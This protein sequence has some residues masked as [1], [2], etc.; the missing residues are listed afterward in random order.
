MSNY[1]D[2]DFSEG[3]KVTGFSGRLL[4]PWPGYIALLLWVVGCGGAQDPA[5]WEG[6]RVVYSCPTHESIDDHMARELA[7]R[8]LIGVTEALADAGDRRCWRTALTVAGY[9][10]AGD[11]LRIVTSF[12]GKHGYR[13]ALGKDEGILRAAFDNIA[14]LIPT[15]KESRSPTVTSTHPASRDALRY[16]SEGTL[17]GVW[18]KRGKGWAI[19]SVLKRT[20]ARRMARE[21]VAA[22]ALTGNNT[23]WIRLEELAR[24]AVDRLAYRFQFQSAQGESGAFADLINVYALP[25]GRIAFAISGTMYLLRQGETTP[26]ATRAKATE[27]GKG[28][29]A[30]GDGGAT[31]P[32]SPLIA[33]E[34]VTRVTSASEEGGVESLGRAALRARATELLCLATHAYHGE[35]SWSEKIQAGRKNEQTVSTA[36]AEADK[37]LSGFLGQLQSQR[38][39]RLKANEQDAIEKITRV[40]FPE[41]PAGLQ[42]VI[43]GPF[44]DQASH[45]LRAMLI[46][47]R[48]YSEE[49]KLLGL[50]EFE[51]VVTHSHTQ[52][53]DAL[54][55]DT[56]GAGFEALLIKRGDLQR[57]LRIYIATALAVFPTDTPSDASRRALVLGPLLEQN[58]Q[59]DRYLRQG[60]L[61]VDVDPKTG[62]ELEPPA[63]GLTLP[64]QGEAASL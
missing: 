58:A 5:E 53:G 49:M 24:D 40:L 31:A 33:D 20:V 15:E 29:T 11:S 34:C 45:V 4:R 36:D 62:F 61:V 10:P 17:P 12:I 23:A 1:A 7:A 32:I 35:R 18:L 2:S 19:D 44:A 9:A 8:D 51:K 22:L 55:A 48:D 41:F 52:L 30:K 28:Q 25:P 46:L 3:G 57:A 43:N 54:L 47:R 39:L 42:E 16:L 21:S 14:H 63:E 38:K 64:K 6:S 56:W 59:V 26:S 13:L 27:T 37:R 50:D 60:E